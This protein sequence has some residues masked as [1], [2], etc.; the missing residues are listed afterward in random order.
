MAVVPFAQTCATCHLDQ[1]IG[2]E[3]ATGPKGI[4]FL[5]LPGMDLETLRS[6]NAPIG[7]WPELSEAE[8]TPL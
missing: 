1:I 2:K 8:I 5:S 6:K 4:A 7:E 3:R